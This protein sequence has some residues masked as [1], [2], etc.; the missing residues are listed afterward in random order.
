VFEPLVAG[1]VTAAVAIRYSPTA[2]REESVNVRGSASIQS[3]LQLVKT[4]DVTAARP[5][6]AVTYVLRLRNPGA[7]TASGVVVADVLPESVGA[8]VDPS[9]GAAALQPTTGTAQY[10]PATRT[11]NWSAGDFAQFAEASLRY[12]VIVDTGATG[13]ASNTASITAG[14]ANDRSTA[15]NVD[16]V[17]IDVVL[18]TSD[19]A[20]TLLTPTVTLTAHADQDEIDVARIRDLLLDIVNRGSNATTA[21]LLIDGHSILRLVDVTVQRGTSGPRERAFCSPPFPANGTLSW[22]GTAARPTDL[23][24]EAD[25]LLITEVLAPGESLRVHTEI[26]A[27]GGAGFSSPI[28]F[29]LIGG[30]PDPV[31]EDNTARAGANVL[32]PFNPN[33]SSRCF[34]ATA[35]YGSYLEPEVM[36]LRRFRDRWLLTNAPGRTFV[37]WYY[38]TSPPIADYIA[39]RPALR[40]L[41]RGLLTPLVYSI[42]YPWPASALTFALLFGLGAWLPRRRQLRLR[43]SLFTRAIM[44]PAAPSG[45]R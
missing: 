27:V 43:A 44:S 45:S 11:I 2:G 15:D 16:S 4:A 33:N 20:L 26:L 37:E 31:P 35:A 21:R 24:D 3:D 23:P 8:P 1:S 5:G 18:Y 22:A 9:T 29:S 25:C 19:L 41:V 38:R 13:T 39:K 32:I 40:A 36:V 14:T 42:K 30:N 28:D 10:D 34:I 12:R 17:D 6:D 7:A